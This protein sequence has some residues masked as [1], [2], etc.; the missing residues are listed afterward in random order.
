MPLRIDTHRPR[1]LRAIG[2]I[3]RL[4]R[5]QNLV[6]TPLCTDTMQ[7]EQY[8]VNIWNFFLGDECGRHF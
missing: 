4:V 5:P 6:L 1:D 8:G 3:R 7:L 2:A